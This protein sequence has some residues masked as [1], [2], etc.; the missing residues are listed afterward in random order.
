MAKIWEKDRGYNRLHI[1]SKIVSRTCFSSI[2]V[3]GLE[4]IPKDGAVLLAPNHVAAMV[5]P[6]VTVIPEFR[7]LLCSM[8]LFLVLQ[9]R[10][11]QL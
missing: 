9:A 6:K 4:N 3:E 11:L 2:K 10:V 7:D 8:P 5:D 1:Y